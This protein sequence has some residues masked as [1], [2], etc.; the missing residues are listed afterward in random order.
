MEL[1]LAILFALNISV[2]SG[3]TA[4]QIQDKHPGEYVHAKTIIDNHTYRIDPESG[5]V[6]VDETGD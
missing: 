1:L 3:L 5:I 6:I 2:E 4:E